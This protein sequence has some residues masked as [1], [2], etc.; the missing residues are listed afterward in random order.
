MIIL[1]KSIHRKYD[2]W[3]AIAITLIILGALYAIK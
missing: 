2:K 1:G 3:I